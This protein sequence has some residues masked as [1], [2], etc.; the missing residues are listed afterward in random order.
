MHQREVLVRHC[1]LGA[2]PPTRVELQQPGYQ[3][4]GHLARLPE[5]PVQRGSP[6]GGQG[7]AGVT[8]SLPKQL[9]VRTVPPRMNPPLLCPLV[10]L[11][12]PGAKGL[13]AGVCN[14]HSRQVQR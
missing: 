6:I 2:S 13:R 1:L 14:N 12:L 5:A 3:V 10:A 11:S 8:L 9:A 4:H 7:G